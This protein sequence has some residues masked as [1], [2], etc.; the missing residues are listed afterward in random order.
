MSGRT[1]INGR[2]ELEELPLARGGMGEVW[3]GRDV[4][5]ERQVAVKFIRFPEGRQ[6]DELVRR[7]VRE[8]RITARLEHPGVPAVYDVGTH[9]GRPYIVMQRIRG[10]SVADLNAEHGPLPVGW[11]A[12]IAAQVCAVLSVAHRASLVHRDLKPGNLMLDTDGCVK[13]LDFGLAVALEGADIS[14]ITRSGQTLGTPAYMAP[15]QVLAGMSGPATDLYALGCT[16]HEMLTGR[17]PFTGSTAYAVMSKQVDQPPPPVR[18][19]RP[20]VPA[21][22]ERLILAMLEKTPEN[23]PD[24]AETVYSGLLRFATDLGALPGLLARATPFSPVRMYAT[25]LSRI[26]SGPRQP[27]PASPSPA[28]AVPQATAA[29][30]DAVA[31]EPP[32]THPFGRAHLER[33][34]E[35]A[36]QLI[37]QSRYSQ[38]AEVLAAAVG[39]ASRVLGPTDDDVVSLRLQLATVL[40]DGGDYRAAAPIYQQLVA[41]LSA[42]R[43][44]GDEFVLR[45]RLQ[46]ATCHA[47]IGET[48]TALRQLDSLLRDQRRVYGPDDQRTLD[49]RRQIGLLQL[50]AGQRRAAEQ[51]LSQLAADL[52][53]LHGPNHPVVTAVTDL[54]AGLPRG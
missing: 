44:A 12:A 47:L 18:G 30:R 10:I 45:C 20:E 9:E 32:S 33:A 8:S 46:E 35:E 43:G 15:E 13:V 17:A 50:G 48:S 51:T 34:R 53:R 28:P 52:T 4:K 36:N 2:Y 3:V 23:R 38:A 6:D 7:F 19:L 29:P 24:S 26:L 11:A 25:V 21:E 39:S 27:A 16:L 49:L 22:L 41:D 40:F 31:A 1:L 54:L 37:K 14:Q 5:L 42:R